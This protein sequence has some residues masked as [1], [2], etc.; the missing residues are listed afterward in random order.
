MEIGEF[1][2]YGGRRYVVVGFTPFSVTPF[3]VEL[4]DP[5]SGERRSVP[6]PPPIERAALRIVE[7][8]E[9]PPDRIRFSSPQRPG[10][11]SQGTAH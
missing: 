9:D 5:K 8:N 7:K 4:L 6:W 10:M 1:V 3:R 2:T 11:T